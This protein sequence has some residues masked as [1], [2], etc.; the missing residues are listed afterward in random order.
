[1]SVLKTAALGLL[2]GA[3]PLS[4]AL[5]AD[6][7]SP[8][9]DAL[10]EFRS[11]TAAPPAI[12][13][14]FFL[15][16]E[17]FE[18]TPTVGLVTSNPLAKR[19]VG[20]LTFAYHFNEHLAATG[21]LTYSPDLGKAD[22]KPLVGALLQ[23]ANDG[24]PGF[25]Q[26]LDKATL[27]AHFAAR[28]TP[29][30]GKINLV[31]ETVVN[32]EVYG[33][34]GLG[35]LSK[36]NFTATYNPSGTNFPDIVDLTFAGNESKVGPVF[37]VGTNFFLN[38]GVAFRLDACSS[39]YVDDKPPDPASPDTIEQRLYNNFVVSGGLSFFFPKMQPRLYNF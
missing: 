26:P 32:F 35:M 7:G 6:S 22:L 27:G 28:W 24:G 23:I 3:A 36:S 31:G 11:G 14:R 16:A 19:Y 29:L 12:Q 2:L 17:R 30:Y 34:A 21:T 20:G 10:A 8:G 18:L 25:Q 4:S 39:L 1:M 15:K 13:N 5:A 9:L 37:G 33:V 38:Q